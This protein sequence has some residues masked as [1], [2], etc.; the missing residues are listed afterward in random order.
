MLWICCGFWIGSSPVGRW[1]GWQVGSNGQPTNQ[2]AIMPTGPPI[3]TRILQLLSFPT[4][5][6]RQSWFLRKAFTDLLL[7]CCGFCIC[8]SPVGRWAR[9]PVES[10]A[11]AHNLNP[12]GWAGWPVGWLACWLVGW[13]VGQPT[14]QPVIMPTDPSIKTRIP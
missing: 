2:P 10:T 13:P 7:I 6:A 5:F 4:R 9:W 1:A 14:S 11:Q 3:K 8:S 12:V